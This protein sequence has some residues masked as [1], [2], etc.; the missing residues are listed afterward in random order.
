MDEQCALECLSVEADDVVAA[1]RPVRRCDHGRDPERVWFDDQGVGDSGNAD[2]SCAS[3]ALEVEAL[4]CGVRA[5][6]VV[7]R[8]EGAVAGGEVVLEAAETEPAGVQGADRSAALVDAHDVAAC[9][10]Q[11]APEPVLTSPS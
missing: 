9:G 10:S 5:A 1:C 7:E 6:C 8:P 3:S 4:E 2:A 11:T